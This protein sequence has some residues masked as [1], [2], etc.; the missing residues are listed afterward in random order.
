MTI[1]VGRAHIL[2][3]RAAA[4]EH[5]GRTPS[6]SREPQTRVRGHP[7]SLAQLPRTFGRA[8][9]LTRPASQRADREADRLEV[10][11]VCRPRARRPDWRLKGRLKWTLWFPRYP[12]CSAPAAGG[13]TVKA[14][15]SPPPGAVPRPPPQPIRLPPAA[16]PWLSHTDSPPVRRQSQI[17]DCHLYFSLSSYTLGLLQHPPPQV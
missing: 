13:Q 6:E 9:T 1:G 17:S 16:A 3:G 2:P 7:D 12:E 10:P 4:G 5:L 15:S 14:H 8:G 11:R